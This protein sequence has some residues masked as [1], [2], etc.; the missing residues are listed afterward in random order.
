MDLFARAVRSA[1][2]LRF[3]ASVAAVSSSGVVLDRGGREATL[4]QKVVMKSSS[5]QGA[6]LPRD[7]ASD[8]MSSHLSTAEPTPVISFG[9]IESRWWM[10]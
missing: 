9:A 6:S 3:A 8:S 2:A 4:L 1:A 7:S 10:K 5:D